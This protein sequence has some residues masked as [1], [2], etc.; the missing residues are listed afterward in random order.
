[1]NDRAKI[2]KYTISH[3]HVEIFIPIKIP[4][5]FRQEHSG[6]NTTCKSANVQKTANLA[7]KLISEREKLDC[8]H[9]VRMNVQMYMSLIDVQFS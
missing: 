4:S 2:Y 8:V 5:L 7:L 6:M 3:S 1:M 9:R